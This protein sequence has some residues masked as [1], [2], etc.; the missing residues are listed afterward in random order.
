MK[1][2][3]VQRFHFVNCSMKS[4]FELSKNIALLTIVLLVFSLFQL[5]LY[6]SFFHI[7]ITEFID[8]SEIILIFSHK[9]FGFLLTFL[10]IVLV[11]WLPKIL[12]PIEFRQ[13]RT[14]FEYLQFT[15]FRERLLANIK[16]FSFFFYTGAIICLA[17]GNFMLPIKHFPKAILLQTI[18]L[19]LILTAEFFLNELFIW[20][21]MVR[22]VRYKMFISI[23]R[24]RLALVF[25]LMAIVSTTY[26]VGDSISLS[27][28]KQVSFKYGIQDIRTTNSIYYIG[29]TRE[30][31][32]LY[33]KERDLSKVYEMK[34]ISGLTYTR[35]D[36][37]VYIKPLG[38]MK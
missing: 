30:Y 11:F 32:F 36:T 25:F 8:A 4:K 22:N 18:C 21:R 10:F 37:T 20:L 34:N 5:G 31:L 13:W 15:S 17:L 14:L 7:D 9:L 33:D 23:Y 35:L 28:A 3:W 6:F 19:V 26:R 12:K 16:R 1:S 24:F 29:K 2:Y 38:L 27:K